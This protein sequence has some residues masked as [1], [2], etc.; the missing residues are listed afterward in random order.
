MKVKVSLLGIIGEY[1]GHPSL[2]IKLE[3]G[4]TVGVLLGEI[5]E[6]YA[7]RM[8]V[9]LWDPEKKVFSPMINVFL[10]GKDV[11]DEKAALK[12]GSEVILLYMIAGGK[13]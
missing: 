8:P 10:D 5:G 11:E 9:D 2:D 3:E 6:R 12:E 1:V 13:E 4:T 7:E